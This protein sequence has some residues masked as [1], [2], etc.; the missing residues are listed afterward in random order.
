[1]NRL[2]I[3]ILDDDEGIRNDLGEFFLEQ[4]YAVLKAGLPSEAFAIL[5]QQEMDV[6][7]LDAKLP[8]MDGLDVL[9]T[10]KAS[11]PDIEVIMITGHGETRSVVDAMR[12]G[13]FDFFTKP[14]SM[15]EVQN[16]IERTQKFFALQQ[17]L[18]AVETSYALIVNEFQKKLRHPIIGESR[19]I[20][21]ALELM[22]KVAQ[23]DDTAVL[24][25]GESGTGKELAARGI[26][27]LSRRKEHLFC[28]VNCSA[29]PESLF[30]SELFG[31]RKGA[32]TGASE[33]RIGYL[34]AAHHGT[35]FL[36]EIGNIP[37]SYQIKLLRVI[38]DKTCK[39]LGSQ[40][41]FS[42]DVRIISATNQNLEH[43]VQENQFRLDL[44]HRLNTFVIHLL[45]LR[46]RPEDIPLLLDYYTT[47]FA[48]NLSKPITGIAP[49]VLTACKSYH[50]PGNV[51]E[52]K[53][54][55]E[56]AVILCDGKKLTLRHFSLPSKPEQSLTPAKT[57]EDSFNLEQLVKQTISNALHQTDHNKSEA[58][59]LLGISRQALDRK[60]EKYELS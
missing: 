38:E 7:L 27:A 22:A 6:M 11:F 20:K 33:E 5:A 32:F 48:R 36:D 39:R 12:L 9:K 17:R 57:T 40:K 49:Q 19:A 46:E 35:L 2:H 34:E 44:L 23:T 8:E 4:G 18:K 53:N 15:L 58:A 3:L 45:P 59:K 37:L 30:E 47:Y 26:H 25:T 1:M 60:L 21:T 51:R 43:L 41:D 52:L 56:R 50:F 14:F 24:I 29:I 54:L 55:V 31:H 16:A 13:A 10:I 42:V 28:E